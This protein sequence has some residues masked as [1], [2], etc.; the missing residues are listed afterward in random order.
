M[1]YFIRSGRRGLV[2]IGYTTNAQA[3]LENLQCGSAE[4][5][6]IIGL[7]EGD[8]KAESD[9]HRRFAHL[10]LHGEWFRFAPEL[11]RA[12]KPHLRSTMEAKLAKLN[13]EYDDLRALLAARDQARQVSA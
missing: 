2:K 11:K 6:T 9:W 12:A 3:R 10:R 1:I 13:R 8:R 7:A 5:L 4:P